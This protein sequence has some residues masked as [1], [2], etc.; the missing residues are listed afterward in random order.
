MTCVYVS[1]SCFAVFVQGDL[2]MWDL[3]P[4]AVGGAGAAFSAPR[5]PPA[6][7]LLPSALP[8]CISRLSKSPVKKYRPCKGVGEVTP[9]HGSGWSWSRALQSCRPP[10]PRLP[11]CSL[12]QSPYPLQGIKLSVNHPFFWGVGGRLLKWQRVPSS[13][14]GRQLQSPRDA[15]AQWRVCRGSPHVPVFG[16]AHRKEDPLSPLTRISL[17]QQQHN[18]VVGAA[19][20]STC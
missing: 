8:R 20:L 15:V 18:V 6:L 2:C 17:P 12:H 14:A 16:G 1:H 19:Q 4:A 13:S 9:C 10:R 3:S 5:G 11:L 7:P